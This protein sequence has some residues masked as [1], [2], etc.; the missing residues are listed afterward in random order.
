MSPHNFRFENYFLLRSYVFWDITPYNPLKINDVSEENI[1][2]ISIV[3]EEA[4]QES[5]PEYGGD[6]F[7]RKVG[8]FSTDSV[9]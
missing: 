2:F 8:R 7:L 3:E 5:S 1:A 4:K 6:I 9:A